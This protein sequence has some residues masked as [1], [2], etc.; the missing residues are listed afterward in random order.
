M[1]PL[2]MQVT[3]PFILVIAAAVTVYLV[4]PMDRRS[5]ISLG[6]ILI[7]VWAVEALGV[8]TG[9]PFGT[10]MFT[11]QL[12]WSIVSVPIVIPFLR[13]LVIAASDAAVGHFFGRLSSVLVALVATLLTFFMEFA[14][15]S[16]DLWHWRT[17]FPPASSYAGWFVITLASTLL[18]RDTSERNTELRL[19]AHI[20]IGLVIYFCITFI[21]M[22]SGLITL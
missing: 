20:Y 21:G 13:L 19:P 10:Y 2:L 1:F 5:V 22:K 6:G 15:D 3:M 7:G 11:D 8:A 9:F 12:G 14:A 18:L 16:L 4:Y 17:R